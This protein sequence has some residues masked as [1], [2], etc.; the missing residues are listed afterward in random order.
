MIIL[1]LVQRIIV[2]NYLIG[3]NEVFFDLPFWNPYEIMHHIIDINTVMVIP[4]GVRLLH[5]Y[6]NEKFET[7]ELAKEKFE[8][9]LKFLKNQVQPHFLFNTLN[10]LYGLILKKE[11][12]AGEVV[13]KLSELMRYL[14]Y[15]TSVQRVELEKELHHIKNYIELEKIRYGN[16]V[17]VGYNIFGETSGRFI[18]PM[19]LLHF[20][21]NSFKH[22]VSKSIDKA[23]ITVDFTVS[24]NKYLLRIENSKPAITGYLKSDVMEVF[25]GV[26]LQNVRRRLDIIYK[27][28]YNLEIINKNDTYTI[29]LEIYDNSN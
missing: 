13:L 10:T 26:G 16:R 4:A 20:V 12:K 1:G 11:D 17:D 9:E 23:W 19:L 2:F 28:D 14:L 15:E 6:Y 18:S 8:A 7:T 27:E 24:D 21:E 3:W 22:G 5:I 29:I 25:A